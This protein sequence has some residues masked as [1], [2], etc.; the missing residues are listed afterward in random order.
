MS[1]RVEVTVTAPAYWAEHVEEL[2]QQHLASASS[3]RVVEHPTGELVDLKRR[4]VLTAPRLWVY[5]PKALR[6]G[7]R[8][9]SHL[10]LP[11]EDR[12][13]FTVSEAAA[14]L[15][16]SRSFAYEAAKKGEIPTMHIG[17]RIL[18]PKAALERL[19]SGEQE[20]HGDS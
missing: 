18:V 5:Y 2:A 19:L 10:K 4:A 8:T 12:L 3:N 6:E 9:A 7:L 15:G 17:R 1:E 13:V 14:L 20:T 11:A 16:I